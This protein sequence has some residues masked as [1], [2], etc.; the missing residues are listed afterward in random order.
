MITNTQEISLQA[1]Y[2]AKDRLDFALKNAQSE[3]EITGALKCF[4]Y[5]FELSWKTMKRMLEAR[6]VRDINSPRTVF[7]AAFQNKLID[8]L[9]AWNSFIAQRNLTSH[10]YDEDLADE[11]FRLLPRFAQHLDAFLKTAERELQ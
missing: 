7:V 8:N 3:L 10:T 4:E 9:D 5:C 1:L 6:G 2:K 11:V